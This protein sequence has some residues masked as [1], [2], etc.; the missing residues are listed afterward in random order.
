M[1]KFLTAPQIAKYEEVTRETV[2]R[3][4]RKGFFPGTRKV[5]RTYKIPF[6]SYNLWKEQ[7]YLEPVSNINNK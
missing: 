1:K 7:T 6:E 2:G 5:G 4:I 3:W